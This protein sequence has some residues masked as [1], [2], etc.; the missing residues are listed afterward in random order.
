MISCA[1]QGG[2]PETRRAATPGMVC[3]S[4]S[5]LWRALR[6]CSIQQRCEALKYG[7]R[8]WPAPSMLG[9]T[10]NNA[11]AKAGTAVAVASPMTPNEQRRAAGAAGLLA[12]SFDGEVVAAARSLCGLLKKADLDPAA[13][14]AAGL[15][16]A[17]RPSPAMPRRDPA[18]FRPGPVPVRPSSGWERDALMARGCPTLT[19]W[20]REFLSSVA[21]LR[22][23]SHKQRDRLDGILVKAGM[24]S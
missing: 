9:G 1:L 16:S 15:S 3:G 12:S 24:R 8:L 5:V 14:V 7:V 23:L 19:D 6:T 17:S 20:E 13:V 10:S 11:A 2:R 21:G 4:Q 22:T 18:S